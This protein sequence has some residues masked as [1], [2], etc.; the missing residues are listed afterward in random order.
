M[1]DDSSR[2]ITEV[3]GVIQRDLLAEDGGGYFQDAA[4]LDRLALE[5]LEKI[6]KDVRVEGWKWAQAIIDFP[7]AHGLHR[8]YPEPVALLPEDRER[9]D[10]VQAE[11]DA[12][13]EQYGGTDELPD[14]IDAKFGKLEAEIERLS[15]R[16]YTYQQEAAARSGAFVVLKRSARCAAKTAATAGMSSRPSP[17]GSMSAIAKSGSRDRRYGSS[18]R[19]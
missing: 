17:S 11:F 13:N 18:G 19:S 9:L 14:E 3:G 12:L 6:A 2:L 8:Y 16:Q 15:E 10:A 7:H 4:L 1:S 5:R